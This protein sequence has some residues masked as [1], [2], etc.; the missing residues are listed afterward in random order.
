M[1]F[2]LSSFR[3][4]PVGRLPFLKAD[5]QPSKAA[6]RVN[7]QPAKGEAPQ[8]RKKKYLTAKYGQ[9]QMSLIRKRLRVEMW[10]FDQLQALYGQREEDKTPYNVEID[11]D[12][13]LDIEGDFN[14][15]AWLGGKVIGTKKS[16]ENVEKFISELLLRAKTL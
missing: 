12:E 6:L 10:I 13:L 4:G 8:E 14:R 16:E 15:K 3:Q 11:L 9:H 5:E 2:A 1:D 7:F